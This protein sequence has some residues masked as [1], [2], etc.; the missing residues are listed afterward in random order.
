MK[1]A[2][3]KIGDSLLFH[4]EP[5]TTFEK[6]IS[7]GIQ[8]ITKSP[9]NHVARYIGDGLFFG[10]IAEGYRKQTL[11]EAIAPFDTV[12]VFRWHAD[13]DELTPEQQQKIVERA[14]YYEDAPYGYSQI[15]LLALLCEINNTTLASHIL[16][17]AFEL[18]E[19]VF[20]AE[21]VE[22]INTQKA[23]VNQFFGDLNTSSRKMLICSEADYR[24]D[25]ETG[26]NFRILNDDS[27]KDYYKAT[28]EILTRYRQSNDEDLLHPS[29]ADFI[30][31]RDIAM[32]PD[33]IFIDTLEMP[34]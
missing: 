15:A 5:A 25:I 10:A 13:E 19:N 4:S 1:I 17:N 27:R 28:G 12:D 22:F 33:K 14:K 26:L 32:S 16:T 18:I 11:D 9:Y 7:F 6:I 34:K 30:V 29:V 31:P 3:L 20:E 8:Q 2:E 23:I 24:L 21:V